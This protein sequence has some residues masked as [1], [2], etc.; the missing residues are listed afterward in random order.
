MFEEKKIKELVLVSLVADSYSLGSHW[1]YDENQLAKDSINWN[2]LNAP[3]A[4]WHKGKGAGEFTHYGDQTLWLYEFILENNNFNEKEFSKYWFEKM[5]T[6][7]GYLDSA[8]KQSM[9]NIAN[10]ITPSGSTSTDMSVIGRIAPLLLVS[11]NKIEFL[12]NVE[13]LINLTHNNIKTI[14][15]GK[16]FAKLLL[17]V[18]EGK[19]I[20]ESISFLKDEF[21]TS[22]QKMITRGIDSKNE[23]TYDS[24]RNFGPACD[25]DDG[26][27]GI[28]H[29][30]CKYDNLKELL[31]QNAKAGGD[32]S[33]RAMISSIIFM[34]NK[35]YNQIPQEWLA[36][37]ANIN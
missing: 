28:I 13:K 32:T 26:F 9:Q 5:K 30:L 27:S 17:M 4:I 8:S 12:Q 19:N 18:L 25:I 14:T 35:S 2:I 11:E 33:S 1:V 15:C 36:I 23:N 34:A 20:I 16:F 29:L 31:I 37:K 10:G 21:D 6:Y 24:I 22:I 3:M 7:D